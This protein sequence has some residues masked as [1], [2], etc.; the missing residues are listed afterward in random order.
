[1][2][3]ISEISSADEVDL[4]WERE[5]LR[6]WRWERLRSKIYVALWCVIVIGVIFWGDTGSQPWKL[7]PIP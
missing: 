1:M 7:L 5:A 2:K 3:R 4:E 6:D